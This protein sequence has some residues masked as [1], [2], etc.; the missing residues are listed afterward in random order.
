MNHLDTVEVEVQFA[1]T[2]N[3]AE[4]EQT[5]V[6]S[7]PNKKL[8]R[9]LITPAA[10]IRG[11]SA[12]SVPPCSRPVYI[13][14]TAF[15]TRSCCREAKTC[16]DD[17]DSYFSDRSDQHRVVDNSTLDMCQRFSAQLRGATNRPLERTAIPVGHKKNMVKLFSI[18]R[19]TNAFPCL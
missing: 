14:S 1:A 2:D 10:H 12:D 4:F 6:P 18:S 3:K 13:F 19:G 8:G 7:H 16:S 9:A 11:E 17:M 15:T 5:V